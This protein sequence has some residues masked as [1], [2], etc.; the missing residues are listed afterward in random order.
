MADRAIVIKLRDTPS[1]AAYIFSC[2]SDGTG[3]SA[4]AKIDISAI[5][6]AATRVR[7][8]KLAWAISGQMTAELLFDHNTDDSAGILAGSGHMDENNM[9]PILDPASA[10]GAGDI[11]L[12][13]KVTTAT[14][15]QGYW[16]YIEIAKVA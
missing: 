1:E 4:A 2:A 6:M 9:A 5:V 16:I 10:G 3:E 7:I 14:V 12:T 8:K 15:G 13:S 11:L